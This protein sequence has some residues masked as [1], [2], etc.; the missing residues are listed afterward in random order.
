MLIHAYILRPIY[1][2]AVPKFISV[3]LVPPDAV[4]VDVSEPRGP[5]DTRVESIS[6]VGAPIQIIS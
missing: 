5:T 1:N 2:L 6:V 3:F 4:Y